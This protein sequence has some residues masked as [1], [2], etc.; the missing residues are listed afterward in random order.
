MT[1]G[2]SS[3]RSPPFSPC[4]RSGAPEY[5]E[6]VAARALVALVLLAAAAAADKDPFRPIKVPGKIAEEVEPKLPKGIVTEAAPFDA[7]VRK[8]LEPYEKDFEER[9]QAV[10]ALDPARMKAAFAAMAKENADWR[11]RLARVEADYAEVF[12]RGWME[13]SEKQ[14]DTRKLAA[15]LV[16]FY[17][18]LLLRNRAV[19]EAASPGADALA[20]PDEELRRAAARALRP[21][22][23]ASALAA[24]LRAA[25][26]DASPR[27][28]AAALAALLRWKISEMRAA[29]VA[30][31]ADPAWEVRALAIAILA[32]AKLVEAVPSLVDALAREKGRLRKDIDD[33]LFA[34]TG[35]KMYGDAGLWRDWLASNG[36]WIA[37]KAKELADALEYEKT[38]EAWGEE[39]PGEEGDEEK[40]K[41]HT[42]AFYGITTQSRR[43]VFVVDISQSMKDPAGAKPAAATGG[44]GAYASPKGDTKLDIAKWQLHRAIEDLPD[45]AVFGI[46]V[47]SESYKA[48]EEDLVAANARGK[49]KAHAFVDGIEGNGT[50]N[51]SDSLD[52]ALDSGA[53]TIFLLSD[54]D[55]NRGRVS[56]LDALLAELL[57]R[58]RMLR[59]VIHTVGIGE[60]E[61]SAF[62]KELAR[63]TGGRYVGFR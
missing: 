7:L 40:R 39:G 29:P 31:L 35:I 13:A 22:G 21:E 23:G 27:V 60:V 32:R 43:V 52:R 28:R 11:K 53:D 4:R 5:R 56:G 33:A 47:Y 38:L 25:K 1:D 6:A 50:T 14:R 42:S 36:E 61:G 10:A 9:R 8:L 59:V 34:L 16:P 55:P 54:G 41:G 26:D 20:S 2:P 15:V 58:N 17:R 18:T 49:K 30:A 44:K 62:L 24:L 19:A 63:A 48:W 12:N 37:A 51:I 46:I 45:D 3:P 57:G